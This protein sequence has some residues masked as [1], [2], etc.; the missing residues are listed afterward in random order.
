ML[1]FSIVESGQSY[2]RTFAGGEL[3]TQRSES[4]VPDVIESHGWHV[5]STF[6]AMAAEKYLRADPQQ[7]HQAQSSSSG[8]RRNDAKESKSAGPATT[9]PS[10][11]ER[12]ASSSQIPSG[13]RSRKRKASPAP[14]PDSFKQRRTAPKKH[15]PAAWNSSTAFG[16]PSTVMS[17]GSQ[18][19]GFDREAPRVQTV[20][21]ANNEKTDTMTQCQFRFFCPNSQSTCLVPS[22]IWARF[23]TRL[24]GPV[25]PLCPVHLP[26]CA[27]SI[28]TKGRER[29]KWAVKHD[30]KRFRACVLC[31]CTSRSRIP[32]AASSLQV[33]DGRA[34]CRFSNLVEGERCLT[35]FTD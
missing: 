27:T 8:A 22:P 26:E 25:V 23:D 21:S 31:S 18:G 2:A 34:W 32:H 15:E 17:E 1:I 11:T 5:D 28:E 20:H 16:E 4:P 33:L 13:S 3:R 12:M 6:S 30:G 29:R 10:A 14:H 19:I 7:S 24:T 35:R 9:M